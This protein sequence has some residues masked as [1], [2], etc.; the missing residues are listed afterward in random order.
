MACNDSN[1]TEG[2]K[3]STLSPIELPLQNTDIMYIVR[4]DK[5][6]KA[7]LSDLQSIDVYAIGSASNIPPF[8]QTLSLANA[9]NQHF[10][11]P[12]LEDVTVGTTYLIKSANYTGV[13]YTSYDFDLIDNEIAPTRVIPPFGAIMLVSTATSWVVV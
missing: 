1:T 7:K 12:S 8:G 3:L 9:N 6:Y 5:S 10:K 11:L 4:G 13:T 2:R